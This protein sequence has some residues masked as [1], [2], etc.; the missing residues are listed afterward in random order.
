VLTG[1]A[2]HRRSPKPVFCANRA[3]L[4]RIA[5]S[6]KSQQR[7]VTHDERLVYA[8]IRVAPDAGAASR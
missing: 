3:R 4:I 5:V 2:S 1:F 6:R 7:I 8:R